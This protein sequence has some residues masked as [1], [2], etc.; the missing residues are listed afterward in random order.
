MV[1]ACGRLDF[2][3]KALGGVRMSQPCAID[4]F[5]CHQSTH[6]LVLGLVDHSHAA[7]AEFAEDAVLRVVAKARRYV[8]RIERG[9]SRRGVGGSGLL[10][11]T[12]P[13]RMNT[14]CG[15][16]TPRMTGVC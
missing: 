9:R 3:V 8:V 13:G 4:D 10:H 15:S 2:P 16:H 12:L 1:K 14:G 11:R 5:E 7:A 6:D